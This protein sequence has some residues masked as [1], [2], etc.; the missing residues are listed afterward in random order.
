M[1][2]E[3]HGRICLNEASSWHAVVLLLNLGQTDGI[4]LISDAV[5]VG[6]KERLLLG[7]PEQTI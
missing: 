3:D 1:Y 6:E 5:M 4:H 7:L 2:A